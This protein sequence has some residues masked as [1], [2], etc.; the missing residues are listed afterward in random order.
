MGFNLDILLHAAQENPPSAVTG[1][2]GAVGHIHLICKNKTFF[3]F[4]KR[5]KR[6]KSMHNYQ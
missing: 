2:V 3:G 4:I 6:V 1:R 5:Q